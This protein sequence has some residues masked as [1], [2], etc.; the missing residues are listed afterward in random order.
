M[1]SE[2]YESFFTPLALDFWQAAVPPAATAAEVDFLLRELGVSPPARLLD[3]PSGAGRHSLALAS[4]G[5]RMTGIDVS[6][7]AI[8]SAQS[9]AN[10]IGVSPTF[11]LGDMRNAP[12]RGPYAGACC[13]GNSFGYLSREDMERFVGHML[14]AVV[15]GGRWVIDTGSTAESLLPHLAEERVLEAG[16]VTYAVRNQYDAVARRLFQSCRLARGSEL[17]TAH[18]SHSIYTLHE[19]RQLLENAGWLV[20]RTYGS[21][22]GVPFQ[23]GDR[24][25]LLIAQRPVP[26][27]S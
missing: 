7:H 2:W 11:L 13:L 4:R 15:P 24:R 9:R 14:Q 21:L 18:I 8:S 1:A 20:L 16:G 6:L 27:E 23:T 17:Q 3:L 10:T 19:L 5:Y 22:E 12:P 25:L 26:S